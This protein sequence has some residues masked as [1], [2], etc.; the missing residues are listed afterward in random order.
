M[1]QIKVSYLE[2]LTNGGFIPNEDLN[3]IGNII[4]QYS[5]VHA[6]IEVYTGNP[7][8]AQSINV[9]PTNITHIVF[10][11]DIPTNSEICKVQL[12]TNISKG[13]FNEEIIEPCYKGEYTF[14]LLNPQLD[15]EYFFRIMVENEF[16]QASYS[17]SQSI[18]MD[19]IVKLYTNTE[20]TEAGLLGM[21]SII[22]IT[23]LIGII[24]LSFG[25]V[26]LYRSKSEDDI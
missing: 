21:D 9:N 8:P 24:M 3:E 15:K 22:P 1:S 25:G 7:I 17:D 6:I 4:V 13:W 5:G 10:E 12:T 16:G 11:Y 14:V 19:D 18:N 26:L 2:G 23:A 20:E